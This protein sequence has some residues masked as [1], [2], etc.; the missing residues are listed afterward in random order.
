MEGFGLSGFP[1]IAVSTRINRKATSSFENGGVVTK[2]Y[3]YVSLTV[4][5]D[6]SKNS[7]INLLTRA[8]AQIGT[9]L[10][11]L[12]PGGAEANAAAWQLE[13]LKAESNISLAYGERVIG[14]IEIVEM[15]SAEVVAH[16]ATTLGYITNTLTASEFN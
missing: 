7:A 12:N 5:I 15:R 2:Q 4:S 9:S 8:F 13:A 11:Q 3:S 14:T 16:L 1:G 6:L 10:S